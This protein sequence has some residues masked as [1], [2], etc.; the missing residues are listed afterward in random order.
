[1]HVNEADSTAGTEWVAEFSW[2]TRVKQG[3]TGSL[4]GRLKP[5][6]HLSRVERSSKLGLRS[7]GVFRQKF[8]SSASAESAVGLE[9]ILDAILR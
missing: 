5:A 4:I 6:L 7:K 3:P 9:A 8:S 1:M 2:V